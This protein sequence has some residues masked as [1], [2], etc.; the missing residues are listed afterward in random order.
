MEASCQ[1]L[2]GSAMCMPAAAA[3]TASAGAGGAGPEQP[4]RH[5]GMSK[6]P[7]HRMPRLG[8]ERTLRRQAA[9][10]T[11]GTRYRAGARKPTQPVKKRLD[12]L[13][14]HAGASAEHSIGSLLAYA[15]LEVADAP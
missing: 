4:T 14:L 1:S 8:E 10:T 15:D 3:A 12:Q 5:R 11:A 9:R 13:H 7:P 6:A 2:T